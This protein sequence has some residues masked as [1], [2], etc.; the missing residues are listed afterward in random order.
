VAWE[1]DYVSAAELKAWERIDDAVDDTQL[2]L[3]VTAASRAVDRHT[4]RQFG[5]VAAAEE[6]RYTAVW[7]RRRC[8]WL[9]EI[10]DL[11]S[12]TGLTFT[13][14]AG[15]IGTYDLEPINAAQKGRPWERVVIHPDSAVKPTSEQHGVTGDGLWGWSTVPATVKL[16]S[17]LQSAR[18]VA[19]RDSPYG[20]AGSPEL[21]SELRLLAR[22]DPDVAVVLGP[23][24]RWWGAAA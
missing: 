21:G 10:D 6:R 18:F 24:V 11:M 19:R 13:T 3:I 22:V 12:T 16:A 15:Q 20:I 14:E 17:R 7:D 8:R 2:A 9:I 4:H 5:V 23:Y 1:P